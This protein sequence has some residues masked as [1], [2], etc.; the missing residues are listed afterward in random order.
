MNNNQV[1]IIPTP[2]QPQGNTTSKVELRFSP[3]DEGANYITIKMINKSGGSEPL[4]GLSGNTG[5]ESL[6]SRVKLNMAS[7]TPSC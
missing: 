3:W 2:S 1:A 4:F 5:N 6:F 7:G